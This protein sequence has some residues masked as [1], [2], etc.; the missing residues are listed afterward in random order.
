MTA[1]RT[2]SW[3]PER[4]E[5]PRRA[6]LGAAGSRA[7]LLDVI[8]NAWMGLVFA[9]VARDRIR[10][11]GVFAG[12]AFALVLSFVG[13]VLMPIGLY[14]YLA[15]TAWAWMYLVDPVQVPALVVVPLLALHGGAL[16]VGYWAGGRLL[17]AER[18][19]LVA[20]LLA[21]G[22]LVLALLVLVLRARLFHYGS[23]RDWQADA[24][25]DLM[26]VKLGYVLLAMLPGMAAAAG[27]VM[28]ELFRDSR[29]VR[30]R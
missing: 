17:R 4:S 22:A 25:L 13:V 23:Y 7:I 30:T 12:P 14:M 20:Y 27:Y 28:L 26:K 8:F 24:T 9:V 6:T 1:L 11:D 10:A 3:P 21:G 29:R 19:R 15:H 2:L 18:A 5:G 16:V